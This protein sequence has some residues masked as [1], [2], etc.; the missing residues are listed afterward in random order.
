MSPRSDGTQDA[1]QTSRRRQ[2]VAQAALPAGLSISGVAGLFL[3]WG[4]P[5]KAGDLER[6]REEVGQAKT[7]IAVVRSSVE[8][9]AEDVTKTRRD[10]EDLKA[11]R[12]AVDI[13]VTGV[14]RRLDRMESKLD[15]LLER[16]LR[17]GDG[18]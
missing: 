9:L 5:A 6:V 12:A 15:R 11:A 2:A 10:V 18:K 3:L 13:A 16:S 4:T 17:A 7:Q 1:P 14:E 8:D